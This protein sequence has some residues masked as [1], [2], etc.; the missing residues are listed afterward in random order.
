MPLPKL[1]GDLHHGPLAAAAVVFPSVSMA[2]IYVTGHEVPMVVE[3]GWDKYARVSALDLAVRF[4]LVA[5]SIIVELEVRGRNGSVEF[6]VLQTRGDDP[7]GYYWMLSTGQYR[8]YG[9]LNSSHGVRQIDD[10]LSNNEWEGLGGRDK[11][12]YPEVTRNGFTFQMQYPIA[13]VEG[14]VEL[15]LWEFPHCKT[16]WIDLAVMLLDKDVLDRYGVPCDIW[17]DSP[18]DPMVWRLMWSHYICELLGLPDPCNIDVNEVIPEE[19]SIALQEHFDDADKAPFWD[20]IE[21]S[22]KF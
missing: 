4:G 9:L 19:L 6:G 20:S 2:R 12:V 1:A 3:M 5:S 21:N 14:A 15:W 7:E 16:H 11:S 22:E 13:S 18:R 10:C 8:A 17:D